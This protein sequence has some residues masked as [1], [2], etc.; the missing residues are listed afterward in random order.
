[1][2]KEEALKQVIKKASKFDEDGDGQ[3]SF[4]EFWTMVLA[5]RDK[6]GGEE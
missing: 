2:N 3:L 5:D 6:C 4:P 1:M